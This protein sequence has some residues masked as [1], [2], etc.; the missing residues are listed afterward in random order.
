MRRYRTAVIGA[1]YFGS[2]HAA[3]HAEIDEAE[4][5]A[6]CD[7]DRERAEAMATRHGA[8]PVLD[9]RALFGRVDAVSVAVPTAAHY[10]VARDCLEAGV[11]VLIEKPISSTLDE[12]DRLTALAAERRLVLQVG[13]LE[14]FNPVIQ[15]LAAIVDRP[16]FIECQ[17]ISAFKL[18]GTDVNVVLDMMI[19]DID[20]VLKIVGSPL[21]RIDAVG[22]PVLS[23]ADDIANARLQFTNGCTAT[24]T[25]SRVSWKRHRSLRLFQADAY[26]V[27]D[28]TDSRLTVIRR[29]TDRN[30]QPDLQHD[31]QQF[32]AGD[33]LK[34]EI[35]SFLASVGQGTPP[36]VSGA[37]GR[38]ALAAALEITRQ[39]SAWRERFQA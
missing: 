35:Q 3:K 37:E 28:M 26:V 23:D 33:P 6:V 18:R 38:A 14:R 8:E 34:A 21:E 19:H 36:A 29:T 10:Q 5:V 32:E 11:H 30:G 17:R 4:L 7:V 9:Y 1:G 16:R 25:A 13:H 27:V 2:L 39:L 20:L 12:A 24:V 22:V 15:A 31:E